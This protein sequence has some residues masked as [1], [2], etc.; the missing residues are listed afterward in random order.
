MRLKTVIAL[1]ITS[2]PPRVGYPLTRCLES[3]GLPRRS[4][5]KIG[6]VR[7]F[8]TLRLGRRIGRVHEEEVDRIVEGLLDIVGP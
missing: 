5:V 2:G 1:S 6:H 4:W 7:T 3:G 8:S